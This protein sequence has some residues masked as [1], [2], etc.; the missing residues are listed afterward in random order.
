MHRYSGNIDFVLESDIPDGIEI[1]NQAINK[2]DED[3]H[4]QVWLTMYPNMTEKTFVPFEKFY[5]RGGKEKPKS[6]V[7]NKTPEEIMEMANK[8][9]KS[10]RSLSTES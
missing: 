9:R 8:I 4:W 2:V 10:D 7:S 3:K 1:I 5:K 6:K